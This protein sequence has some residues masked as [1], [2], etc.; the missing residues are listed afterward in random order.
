MNENIHLIFYMHFKYILVLQSS[1]DNHFTT[2]NIL[3]NLFSLLSIKAHTCVTSTFTSELLSNR[4]S[5]KSI[6]FNPFLVSNLN[7]PFFC[8]QQQKKQKIQQF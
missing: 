8:R 6:N 2:Y 1:S 4:L 7:Q 3:Q 5:V